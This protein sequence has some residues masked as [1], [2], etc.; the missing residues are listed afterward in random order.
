ML[1]RS[2]SAAIAARPRFA[3]WRPLVALGLTLASTGCARERRDRRDTGTPEAGFVVA[4]KQT[5]ALTTELAGRTSAFESSE[6]RPQVTGIL[7]ARLF[8]EGTIVHAGQTLYQIDPSLYQAA[9]AQAQANLQSAQASSVAAKDRADRFGPLA[10]IEAVSKQDYI[11]AVAQ[12][13]QATAS[14][15]QNRAQLETARI[16]LA[17]TRV[18]APITGRIGRSF[19]TMGALVTANQANPLAVIQR[20]DPIFVDIQQSS[21][22]MLALRRKLG[23]AHDATADVSL[24]LEDGSTYPLHGR[25]QFAEAV[26]D[27]GTGTVTLRATFPNPDGLLLP[28][29]YVRAR[30]TQAVLSNVVLVPQAALTRDARGIASVMLVGPGDRAVARQVVAGRTQGDQWVVT[31]GLQGGERVITEGLGRLRRDQPVRPVAAGSKPQGGNGRH[32]RAGAG[33]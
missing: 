19:F 16:N 32:R 28:G 30:L 5:V 21:A 22:D 25:L 11:N 29:M 13:Q 15:A 18:P 17:F 26:V 4:K 6:V 33:A 23:A 27:P 24:Q 14:V 9:A 1:P 20:L 8:T 2:A 31:G 12:Q 3:C 7:K 10:K